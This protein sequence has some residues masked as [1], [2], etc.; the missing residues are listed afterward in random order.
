VLLGLLF[1]LSTLLLVLAGPMP[2]PLAPLST[3]TV[4]PT[5]AGVA[6]SGA[7]SMSPLSDR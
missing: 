6:A 4:L 2:P 5:D 3:S 7:Q 1:Q